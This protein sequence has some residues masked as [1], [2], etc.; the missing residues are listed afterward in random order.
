MSRRGKFHSSGGRFL[1]EHT[2]TSALGSRPHRNGLARQNSWG[3]LSPIKETQHGMVGAVSNF[4]TSMLPMTTWSPGGGILGRGESQLQE[5][6][7]C[8]DD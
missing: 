3:D 6:K 4:Y 8:L 7:S 5:H 1:S 2:R